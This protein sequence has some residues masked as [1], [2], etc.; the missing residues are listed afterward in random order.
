MEEPLRTK[1]VKYGITRDKGSAP[2]SQDCDSLFVFFKKYCG[3]SVVAEEK[4]M[5]FLVEIPELVAYLWE[6]LFLGVGP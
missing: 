1:C 3:Y 4:T 5:S 2:C 6:R